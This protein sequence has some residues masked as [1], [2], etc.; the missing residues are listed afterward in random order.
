MIRLEDMRVNAFRYASRY[1]I[2]FGIVLLICLLGGM[3]ITF[4]LTKEKEP[5]VTSEFVIEENLGHQNMRVNPLQINPYED[6]NLVVKAYYESLAKSSKY[7]EDYENVVI[8]TKLGRYEG[9][10][11]VFAVYDMKIPDIYTRVPGLD[12]LYVYRNSEDKLCVTGEIYTQEITGL[13]EEV[14]GHEDVQTLME[15]VQLQYR[16]AVES[17]AMLEEVL[18]DLQRASQEKE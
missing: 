18:A 6:V 14:V 4:F 11:I 3:I 10:Y 15:E 16:K 1:R 5:Q 12:T 7:A 13:I 9:T 2:Q 8:H 17:D